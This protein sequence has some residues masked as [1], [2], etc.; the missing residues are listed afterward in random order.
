MNI[1]LIV[2]GF[3]ARE[4]DWCIPAL[5]DFVRILGREDQVCVFALRYPQ[6]HEP[7]E[8]YGARVV[9]LA[10]GQHA[11]LRRYPLLVRARSAVM[12]MHARQPFDLIHAIWADEPGWVGLDVAAR[13]ER[14][15]VVSVRGGELEHRRQQR[16]GVQRS[17]FGRVA[18]DRSL[19]RADRW[20]VGST[21]M[22]ERVR[23]RCAGID[24]T[25]GVLAPA[26][27]DLQQFSPDDRSGPTSLVLSV[28]SLTP[29]KQ[30]DLL[31]RA[32][33]HVRDRRPDAELHLVGGGPLRDT[34]ERER[35]GLGLHD[36]VVLHGARPRDELPAWYRKAAVTV[37]TSHH[38]AQCIAAVEAAA[39]GCPV[40]GFP[41]GIVPE[42]G[43]GAR[44]IFERG[45]SAL[46]SGILDLLEHEDARRKMSTRARAAAQNLFG[47]E[48]SVARIREIYAETRARRA[49]PEPGRGTPRAATISV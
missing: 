48:Q 44:V 29:I 35:D 12:S 9:P 24:P 38:E 46:A 34:L 15:L 30:L 36:C 11:G 42:L 7:Y 43:S 10:G 28:A 33:R 31:V 49:G 32:F 2:P 20:T 21:Y 18:V 23:E 1:A 3:S 4:S 8:V 22:M 41:I 27:V 40:V 25:R 5:L 16:Y 26:G 45:E 17:W 19:R 47:L 6:T 37:V 13:L 14:P 39:C